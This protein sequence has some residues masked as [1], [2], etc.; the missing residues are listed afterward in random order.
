MKTDQVE[1]LNALNSCQPLERLSQKELGE[2]LVENSEF[3]L[4]LG[5]PLSLRRGQTRTGTR[6]KAHCEYR[7]E[8]RQSGK[9]SD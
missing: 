7:G 4:E 1:L 8:N 9:N 3:S 5:E 2:L 6:V